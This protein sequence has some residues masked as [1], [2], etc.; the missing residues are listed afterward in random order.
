MDEHQNKKPLLPNADPVP[1]KS[2][3]NDLP[4]TRHEGI[5]RIATSGTLFCMMRQC[6]LL[7][8]T[9]VSVSVGEDVESRY[10]SIASVKILIG[11][12]ILIFFLGLVPTS[13][14]TIIIIII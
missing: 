4:E 6:E 3:G 10:L 14:I 8:L 2:K 5:F 7:I 13:D 11:K 1:V 9:V 12:H